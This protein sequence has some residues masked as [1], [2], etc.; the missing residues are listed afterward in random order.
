MITLSNDNVLLGR[1]PVDATHEPLTRKEMLIFSLLN[2][3]ATG[4]NWKE[5]SKLI[6]D[7]ETHGKTLG[8][9]FCNL[10]KKL[11]GTGIG[12]THDS[13]TGNYTLTKVE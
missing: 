3:T 12:L 7:D 5:L 13:K 9:N 10:R 8:V 1:L 2:C 11:K 4:Y 6:W